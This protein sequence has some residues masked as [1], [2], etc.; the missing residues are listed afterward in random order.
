[1]SGTAGWRLSE[2][3]AAGIDGLLQYEQVW[4]SRGNG[5][6]LRAVLSMVEVGKTY[7]VRAFGAQEATVDTKVAITALDREHGAMGY[8][9]IPRGE[10]SSR[11][12]V[13]GSRS[14]A[15]NIGA[16]RSWR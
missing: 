13:D 2:S 15:T 9:G 6:D 11:S 3:G 5:A 8:L 10:E 7:N 12:V 4:L 16:R 1:M 14:T